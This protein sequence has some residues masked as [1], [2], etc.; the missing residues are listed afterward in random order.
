MTYNELESMAIDISYA[1]NKSDNTPYTALPILL[2]KRSYYETI[3]AAQDYFKTN[4]MI[5]DVD[6]TCK[7]ELLCGITIILIHDNN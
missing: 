7:F 4:R 1:L 5:Q 2:N 3:F 6:G